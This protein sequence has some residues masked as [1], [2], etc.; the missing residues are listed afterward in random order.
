MAK[1]R[2]LA[3]FDR[4]RMK[5]RRRT[6]GLS[7]DTVAER[8]T[9]KQH[10]I[11][12]IETGESGV[13][14]EGAADIAAALYNDDATTPLGWLWGIEPLAAPAQAAVDP[15]VTMEQ[16][17]EAGP[18]VE[19]LG[20]VIPGQYAWVPVR[21]D[22]MDPHILEGD[23][24]RIDKTLRNPDTG[25]VVAM[26]NGRVVV[27]RAAHHR[28]GSYGLRGANGRILPGIPA[29]AYKVVELRRDLSRGAADS[30]ACCC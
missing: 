25:F 28:D 19:A 10:D 12:K 8:T 29:I 14:G 17:A 13:S 16:I 11:S 7:Q 9:Y 30:L 24:V 15:T 6:L 21:G 20:E 4:D 5:R 26:L 18:G 1:D 3:V 2:R 23:D 22:S 27:K